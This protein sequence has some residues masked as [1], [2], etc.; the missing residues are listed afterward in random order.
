MAKKLILGD[1]EL[2]LIR[3]L[4]DHHP[5]AVKEAVEQ[6]GKPRGLARTTILTVMERLRRKAYLRRELVDG[7]YLYA[8]C[9]EEQE[10]LRALTEDFTERVLGGSL[11]PFVAYLAQKA[12]VSDTEFA[13]LERLVQ[14]LAQQKKEGKP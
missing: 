6:F 13:E 9:V 5:I 2:A 11:S 8:P 7:L 14:G 10:V 1:L 12:T 4:A 3:F